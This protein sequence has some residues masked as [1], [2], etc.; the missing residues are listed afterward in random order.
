V[1]SHFPGQVV[2]LPKSRQA[3]VVNLTQQCQVLLSHGNLCYQYTLGVS[4]IEHS[5]DEKDLGGTDGWQA[6]YEPTMCPRSPESPPYP[7]LTRYLRSR[8]PSLCLSLLTSTISVQVP[9]YSRLPLHA[10][11]HD[12][13]NWLPAK[14]QNCMLCWVLTLQQSSMQAKRSQSCRSYMGIRNSHRLTVA[15]SFQEAFLSKGSLPFWKLI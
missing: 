3:R 2:P 5:P 1:W 11:K 13:L 6:G 12:F 4:R 9:G 10:L 14:E 15:G 7:G 8:L